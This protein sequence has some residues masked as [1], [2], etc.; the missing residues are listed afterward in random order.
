VSARRLLVC[1]LALTAAG[2]GADKAPAPPRAA[3]HLDL[4]AP[5][6]GASVRDASVVVRGTVRPAG[7]L[8][9]VRG[10]SVAVAG[11]SF[12]ATVGLAAGTNVIDVLASAPDARPAM[13]ALRVRRLVT[14]RVP[15]VTGDVPDQASDRLAG[16]G[17]TAQ[18]DRA[19]GVFDAL[20][21]G[22]P[23]VC[24]TQPAPG[25]EVDAGTTVRILVAKGC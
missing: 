16:L 10:Q 7:A 23:V 5:G 14:V 8:V 20:L 21:P 9:R 11:G 17:L 2:C 22:D 12:T 25:Q 6:D 13:S 18:V 1:T 3:V 15:D 19:G 24:E 4:A